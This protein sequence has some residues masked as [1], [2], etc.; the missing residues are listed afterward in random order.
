MNAQ[1]LLHFVLN[2]HQPML[3]HSVYSRRVAATSSSSASPP[4][5]SSSSDE[6]SSSSSSPSGISRLLVLVCHR[7]RRAGLSFDLTVQYA[8]TYSPVLEPV[9]YGFLSS[10]CTLSAVFASSALSA[11]RA[12]SPST[13]S[14]AAATRSRASPSARSRASPSAAFVPFGLALS[15]NA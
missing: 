15:F 9:L 7:R 6:P 8:A 12:W 2:R 3:G 5:S 10:P 1:Q 11:C 14:R 13:R 4:S